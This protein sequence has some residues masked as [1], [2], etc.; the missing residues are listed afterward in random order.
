MHLGS[1]GILCNEYRFICECLPLLN[2]SQEHLSNSLS[3]EMA[4]KVIHTNRST[5]LQRLGFC[6]FIDLKKV[7]CAP[8]KSDRDCLCMIVAAL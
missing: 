1:L 8:L 7:I 4:N 6:R 5:G 3:F 2:S